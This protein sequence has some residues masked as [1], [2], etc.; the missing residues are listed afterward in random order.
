MAENIKYIGKYTNHLSNK[1]KEDFLYLFNRVFNLDYSLEWFNWKYIDNIY[2]DSYIVFAYHGDNI[3]GI[4]SFWR[5]DIDSNLSY[6]PCDTAVL[7]EYRGMGIF[8]KMTKIALKEVEGAFIYNFPNENSLPG[9]L[10]LGWEIN[11]YAY[12]ETVWNRGKLKNKTKYIDHNYLIWKFHK[13]PLRKYY[14]YEIDGQTYLLYNRKNNFYYV[15][16]RF[17]GDYKNYFEKAGFPIL[18][19]YT[20]EETM[21][22]KIFKNRA[23]IVSFHKA[24]KDIDIPIFKADYF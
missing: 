14:Y 11:K 8:S 9:N 20:T 5:N 17:N 19:N 21:M 1:E 16:G 12:L 13:S 2:G 6:Q 4:R 23:T 18:F 3:V 7:K 24:E 10:K 22:Y 15:L